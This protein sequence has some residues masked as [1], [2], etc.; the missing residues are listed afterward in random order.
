MLATI[1]KAS[2]W[3]WLLNTISANCSEVQEQAR[4][5]IVKGKYTEEG[6]G[7]KR[8][9]WRVWLGETDNNYTCPRRPR[10]PDHVAME[11]Q[12]QQKVTR[13]SIQIELISLFL[14]SQ[15]LQSGFPLWIT[16]N[17]C[18]ADAAL[19]RTNTVGFIFVQQMNITPVTKKIQIHTSEMA[20]NK[21]ADVKVLQHKTNHPL[22]R[23]YHSLLLFLSF[24]SVLFTRSL[25]GATAAACRW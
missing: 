13:K 24:L 10:E 5:S 7:R 14:I 21:D 20:W 1:C 16:F 8:E 25:R 23:A 19:I 12:V 18:R 11:T 9:K 2:S 6:R 22:S 17:Y 15:G 4:V 3:L